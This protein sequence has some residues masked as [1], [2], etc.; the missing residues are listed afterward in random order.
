MIKAASWNVRGLNGVA[1]QRSVENLVREF[2]LHFLG[3]VETRVREQNA[4]NIQ[5]SLLQNW[6]WFMDYN[7]P[8]GRIWLTWLPTEV[9]VEILQVDRQFIHCKLTN[10]KEHTNCLITVIYGDYDLIPRRD[11]WRNIVQLSGGICDEP[12]LLTGDLML[13]WME[14][15][16]MVMLQTRV[17]QWLSFRNVWQ[18]QS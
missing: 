16:L 14:V 6:S 2:Q 5:N 13:L 15:R 7:G 4:M 11:L 1:H 3:L 12:W 9:G 17:T 8:G 10:K 18:H